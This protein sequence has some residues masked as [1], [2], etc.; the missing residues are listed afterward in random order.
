MQVILLD[1]ANH[2]KKFF[3]ARH[4]SPAN[5]W[6]ACTHL[7]TLNIVTDAIVPPENFQKFLNFSH[8]LIQNSKIEYLLFGHLG[9]C[10]LH[11]HFIPT[12]EQQ[13]LV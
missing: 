7:G 13:F 4:S 3:E 10:H 6:E 11:F 12:P 5:A 8:N 2:R 1:N 9:D